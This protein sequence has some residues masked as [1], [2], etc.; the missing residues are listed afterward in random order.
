MPLPRLETERLRGFYL[1]M[2]SVAV[3]AVLWMMVLPQISGSFSVRTYI[4]RN[5]RLGIDPSVKFYTDLPAMPALYDRIE[6]AN[7]R[8]AGAFWSHWL[9]AVE[10]RVN[11]LDPRTR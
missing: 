9:P 6:R 3:I 8:E 1:L 10:S 2:A 11:S 4:E 7:H 5:E